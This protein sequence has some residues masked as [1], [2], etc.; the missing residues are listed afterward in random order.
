MELPTLRDFAS[1]EFLNNHCF[2][3]GGLDSTRDGT[4]IRIA[5][6][7]DVQIRT[8]DVNGTV[9]LDAKTYQI[10]RADLQ[11]TKIPPGIPDVT[12]VHVT[13]IF[14][15]ISPSIVI[16]RD[17]HGITSLRHW[18]WFATVARTEDQQLYDFEWLR[19]DPAHPTVQP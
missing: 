8:P 15:E 14:S 4:F 7:A 12:A 19:S 11:L 10:R 17:V 5:F 2:R 1:Y 6:Q 18:G 9:Y 16:I 13:T 3:Y